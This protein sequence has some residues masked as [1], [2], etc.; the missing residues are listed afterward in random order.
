MP[1]Y[2][3]RSWHGDVATFESP[4]ITQAKRDGAF[5]LSA[6]GHPSGEI[7]ARNGRATDILDSDVLD[8]SAEAARLDERFRDF[9]DEYRLKPGQN[10][11][12]YVIH[13]EAAY[14][15][16]GEEPFVDIW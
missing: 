16:D 13:S 2:K 12:D 3:L 6:Y 11:G 14:D 5:L 8:A 4:S 10:I 7:V 9:V 15:Y 1:T